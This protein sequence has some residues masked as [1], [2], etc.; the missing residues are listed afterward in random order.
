MGTWFQLVLRPLSFRTLPDSPSRVFTGI[1]GINNSPQL[2][3]N[4]ANFHPSRLMRISNIE[5]I[6]REICAEII[7]IPLLSRLLLV[8]SQ[9]LVDKRFLPIHH[10]LSRANLPERSTKASLTSVSEDRYG[11]ID[12]I[13]EVI[14]KVIQKM[15]NGT[16]KWFNS[17]KG[18][19]FIQPEDGSEDLFFHYSAIQTN[20]YRTVEE[21]QAVDFTAERGPKGMQAS[22]V[23]PS[24]S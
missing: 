8:Y 1:L 22:E 18:Y 12:L 9:R 16:V 6:R 5:L 2:W 19:G 24:N 20:G 23:R 4:T 10:E 15:A 21:G 7:D 17:E 14:T 11:A 13:A 3:K